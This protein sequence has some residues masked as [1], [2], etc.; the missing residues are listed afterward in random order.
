M[1]CSQTRILFEN[2]TYKILWDLEIQ[3]DQLKS[4]GRPDQKIKNKGERERERERICR[5]VD[6][7]VSLD[8]RGKIKESKIIVKYFVLA[9]EL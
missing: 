1:V 2:E 7:S 3:R 4:H 8:H 5:L 9:R 6:L